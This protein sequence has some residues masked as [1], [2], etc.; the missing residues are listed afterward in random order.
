MSG[1]TRWATCQHCGTD[2]PHRAFGLCSACYIYR[3]RTGRERPL[4]YPTQ[5]CVCEAKL[6]KGY[7]ARCC[8]NCYNFAFRHGYRAADIYQGTAPKR[9]LPIRIR[10]IV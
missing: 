9:V 2:A 5:C 3:W 1:S 7:Y 10:G 4:T 6:V 8:P